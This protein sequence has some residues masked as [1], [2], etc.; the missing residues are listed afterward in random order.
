VSGVTT[1]LRSSSVVVVCAAVGLVLAVCV[2]CSALRGETES[3]STTETDPISIHADIAHEWKDE[4]GDVLVLRGRCRVVQGN[5]TLQAQKMVV[6]RQTERS[7]QGSS[8]HVRVYL[9]DDARLE[10]P[11][12]SETASS[13]LFQLRTHSD[14]HTTLRDRSTGSP[15]AHDPLFRRALVRRRASKRKTLLQTQLVIPS[16]EPAGPELRSTPMKPPAGNLRR[17]DIFPRSAVPYTINSFQSKKTTPPEQ[18]SVLDGGINVVIRGVQIEGVEE[19]GTVDLAADRMVIW[20]RA[21]DGD[22]LPSAFQQTSDTPFQVYMEGNIVVR[23]GQNVVRAT[24]AFYDAKEDR[25]LLNNAELKT[26]IPALQTN[27][28]VRAKR[29]RQISRTSFH[30]ENAWATTS[31]FGKP[32]YRI[33]SSDIFVE[34]RYVTP[35]I[36]FGPP[37]ID[38]ATGAAIVKEIPWVTSLNNTFFIEDVPLLYIPNLSAPA[39]DPNIPLRSATLGDDRIF[40]GQVKTVWNMFKLLS[41]D[42]PQGVHWDGRLDYLTD[43]GPAIGTGGHYDGAELF[44]VPGVYSGSGLAYYI[45]DDGEDNLGMDRRDLAPDDNDRG[46]VLLRHR[47]TLPGNMTLLGELGLLSDRNFLEQYYENEFDEQK[48]NETLLYLKQD[49]DNWAWTLLIRPQA[50]EFETTTEWLPKGDLYGLSEPLWGGLMT[51]S[52]HSSVGF[53]RLRPGDPPT[54]P[55]EVFTPLPYVAEAD[56][57][58]LMSRHELDMPLNL[59]PLQM[60]PFVLGEA[61]LWNDGLTSDEIDRLVGSAGVRSSVMV[62]KLFP[63]VQSRIFNL[64]GLAHKVTFAGEYAWTDSSKGLGSIPQYNEFDDNAQERFRE[65]FPLNTFGGVVPTVFEPQFHPARTGAGRSV[66]APYHEL[67][68]DQQVLRLSM[69]HRLQTKVGPPGR[70][71]IKDWMTFEAVVSYFPDA[72]DDNFGENFGLLGGNYRWNVGERTS[73]IANAYYDL[74]DDAQQ[75]WNVAVLS[76]RSTRG[77]VY[78]GLRQ[79]KGAGLDSQILTASY[80]YRMSPKWISTVG[81]AYDLAEN[82]NRGQSLTITRVGADFLVHIGASFDDSKDNAGIAVSV[83]PRFGPFDA[84]STQLSSLLGVR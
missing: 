67:I 39:E 27:L 66:T 75:L 70:Q 18:V 81:T 45:H 52:T 73:L 46:R 31:R 29:L 7:W 74:F 5:T 2:T 65:R 58:V 11:G 49:V 23:Q 47:Q 10:Q 22:R 21:V 3:A 51:W 8:H 84:S 35:W 33:A 32:G 4:Q 15:A 14:V 20:T 30:A 12:R 76:Q 60:V 16:Q 68:D 24:S 17:V 41:W 56:G 34:N 69:R 25:A 57:A 72:A 71:R 82:R 62:W 48:D 83:E 28:R 61:A 78:L 36:G 42:A 43:R 59:G 40:G 6:W 13:M 63:Y 80:S 53:A 54:D 44:G 19:I 79:V 50:N 64:N 9:E 38:P 77:S 55:A 37:P 1:P 26:F